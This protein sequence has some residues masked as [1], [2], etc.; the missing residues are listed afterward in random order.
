[1][2]ADS[3]DDLGALAYR[4]LADPVDH[5]HLL[6]LRALDGHEAHSGPGHGLAD[7]L[8]IGSVILVSLDVWPHVLSRHEAHLMAHAEEQAPPMVRPR[9]RFHSDE[10]G[11]Q[12]PEE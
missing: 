2:A 6:L 7:R 8:G 5:Q 4:H 1:M 9:A 12:P 3:I 11:R 10:A